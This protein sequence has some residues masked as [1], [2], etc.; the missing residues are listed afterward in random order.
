MHGNYV[1][2]SGAS[3]QAL[4][5]TGYVES[6]IDN[7]AG[8]INCCGGGGPASGGGV[9]FRGS[10]VKITDIT[11]GTSNQ[12]MVSEHSDYFTASD[13]SK[14][15]WSAGGLYGW[16][17][18]TDYNIPPNGSNIGDNRQFNCTTIRYP[19]NL[20]T[21]WS[22]NGGAGTQSGDCRVGVCYDLGNN[23]PLNSTHT[24]GVNAVFGD[25]SVRFLS[26]T[27]SLGVLALISVRDDGVPTTLPD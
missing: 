25:G 18:G 22:T 13:G 4:T 24:G 26:D 15:E 6:R 8:S 23:I 9:L 16:T 10:K 17:M 12:M 3:N 5:G 14:R 21:G 7:S 19:I 1:G 11:D 27:T 2:I 20:K